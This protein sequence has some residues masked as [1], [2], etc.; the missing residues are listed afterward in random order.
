MNCKSGSIFLFVL[1]TIVGT[2][3]RGRGNPEDIYNVCV[4]GKV[5]VFGVCAVC[6]GSVSLENPF[7]I[8][9]K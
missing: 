2:S 1:I 4:S 8:L 3:T 6:K 7:H 5:P 9:L